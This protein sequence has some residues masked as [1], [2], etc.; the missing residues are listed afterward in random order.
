M[1]HPAELADLLGQGGGDAGGA[2]PDPAPVQPLSPRPLPDGSGSI[3]L[4]A[5][6]TIH[7]ANMGAVVASGANGDLIELGGYTQMYTQATFGG[8]PPTLVQWGPAA[9]I[10]PAATQSFWNFLSMAGGPQRRFRQLVESQPLEGQPGSQTLLAVYDWDM[11]GKTYRSLGLMVATP[12]SP[13]TWLYYLSSVSAPQAQFTRDL[14]TLQAIWQSRQVDPGVT[15]QRLA[16]AAATLRSC[17]D[18]IA[19]VNANRQRAFDRANDNWLEYIRGTAFVRDAAS[20][21]TREV[22]AEQLDK[23]VEQGNRTEGYKRFNV[24]PRRDLEP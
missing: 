6:W 8:A 13:T 18:I 15:R 1:G 7:E 10:F 20:G 5:G 4:P 16:K 21:E 23:M 17:T 3:M 12:T 14:P 11:N 22:P 9:Q 24:I 2:A 19:D